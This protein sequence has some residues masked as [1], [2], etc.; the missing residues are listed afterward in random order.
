MMVNAIYEWTDEDV[1]QFIKDRQIEVNP[2]YS[3]GFRRVGC[4]LCPLCSRKEKYKEIELFPTYKQAYI[5]AFQKML[6]DERF[7][8]ENYKN[9]KNGEDVFNWWIQ[10]GKD[11]C[12]GQMKFD[13]LE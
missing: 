11:Q 5:N 13:D 10:E 3:M 2:L 8:N 6:D 9:W 7:N 12:E 1:W 4:I